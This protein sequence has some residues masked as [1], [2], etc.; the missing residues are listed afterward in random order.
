MKY[1]Q[2]IFSL[3]FIAIS[4]NMAFAQAPDTT[5]TLQQCLDIAI[6]NNLVVKQSEI[7]MERNRISYQQAR[8]NMLPSFNGSVDHSISDGRSLNPST[9]QYVSTQFTSATY[10]LNSSL[11]LSSGL[12]LQ[13]AV[14]QTSLAYQAGKMDFQQ[15]KDNLTLNVITS[16][17]QVLNAEDQ[18]TQANTQSVVSQK[19]EERQ[20][21]L[22]K[23]GA[24]LPSAYYDLKGQAAAD[25]LNVVN[26]KSTLDIARLTLL[27]LMNVPYNKNVRIQRQL[28][29]QLPVQYNETADQIYNKALTDLAYVK[30]AELRRQSAE[31]SVQIAKGALIPSISLGG[32][33][34]TNYSSSASGGTSVGYVNQLQNNYGT[35]LGVGI[36]VPILNYF[37]NRNK[38]KLAKLDLLNTQYIE[39]NTR[40]Q[41][42]ENIDQA[43][44]N[45]SAA[46]DRYKLLIEQVDA[47]A[48]SFRVAE[49]RFNAGVL[50]SVDFLIVKG[51][52]DR[53]KTSLISSRYDYLIRTKIL[54]YYQGRLSL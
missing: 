49:I 17:L 24:V 6:K 36:N 54:D 1:L 51:N 47:F 32:N 8:E 21:V 4:I 40:I 27:Q 9:N 43:Y 53:A 25:K 50:T 31:K 10:A 16:Y 23:D 44:V 45:M 19:Q 48:E 30:A 52:L 18:L 34:G 20:A 41:L 13:N 5:L 15:A 12:T 26:A 33:L 2:Y 39:Q 46:Y 11:T 3:F 29:D 42:R 14:K 38:I 7:Q 37:Q 35:S 28:A 22:N